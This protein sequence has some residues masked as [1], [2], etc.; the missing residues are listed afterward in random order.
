MWQVSLLAVK[1]EFVQ[2]VAVK[3]LVL[4]SEFVFATV[5]N[6]R[7]GFAEVMLMLSLCILYDIYDS[8]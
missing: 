8:L 7:S 3:A 4:I 2:H 1:N 6:I 5:S